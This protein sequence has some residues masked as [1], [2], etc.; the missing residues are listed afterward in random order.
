MADE[1][2]LRVYTDGAC[3]F[4]W[5]ARGFVEPYDSERRVEFRD[6]NQPEVASET[7]FTPEELAREMH[8]QTPD[9]RWHSGFWGW[10][11][12]LRVLP[13]RRWLARLVSFPPFR[14]I[15]PLVY[16]VLA[17]N[18]YRMPAWLLR[19]MGAPQ[20]CRGTCA[21]AAAPLR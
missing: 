16:R 12:I 21:I 18:R 19:I 3:A 14:W 10:V 4:C 11:A 17:A 7:P 20:P 2:K 6:F 13:R 15:G 5:W 1:T 8:V 9:G